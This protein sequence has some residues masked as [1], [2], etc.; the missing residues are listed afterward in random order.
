MKRA[1]ILSTALFLALGACGKTADAPAGP[2]AGAEAPASETPDTG[3]PEDPVLDPQS[4]VP[5][6]QETAIEDLPRSIVVDDDLLKADIRFDEAVFSFAPAMAMDVVEDARIRIE[7]M[8][9]D[10]AAYKEADPAYFRPYGL[11]I[12]WIVSGA[13]G[14]LASLEGFYF[15]YT[16]GAHGNYL[17]DGRIYDTLTGDQLRPVDLFADPGAAAE[18]MAGDVHD[19]IAREK[20]LRNGDASR[21]DQFLGEAQDAVD[22]SDILKGEV[23][24]IG[25]D[26]EGRLGGLVVHFGPYEIGSYAEGAF[27]I[28]VPQA[29]FHEFLKPEFA[30]AFGGEPVDIQRSDN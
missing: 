19:A 14:T 24:L 25:S 8:H 13:A 10:A 17:T 23:S 1:L 12:D 21:Y 30:T 26:E 29:A 3:A 9:E 22:P 4:L 2:A 6:P 20:T 5:D 18:A 16:G 7:A 11:K 15:T 28:P 27:H